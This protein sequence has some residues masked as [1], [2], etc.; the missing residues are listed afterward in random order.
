M[1]FVTFNDINH[2]Q[3]LLELPFPSLRD[4]CVKKI[5][6][7]FASIAEGRDLQE[8]TSP[9][10]SYTLGPFSNLGKKTLTIRAE[11]TVYLVFSCG[12]NCSHKV[13]DYII[14]KSAGT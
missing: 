11:S 9:K 7:D 3:V 2:D 13:C 12:N 1:D 6:Q 10:Y 8:P 5:V 4:V 14:I